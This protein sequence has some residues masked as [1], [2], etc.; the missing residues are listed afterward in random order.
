MGLELLTGG[1]SLPWGGYYGTCISAHDLEETLS[2]A[3]KPDTFVS[4]SVQQHTE[5][6]PVAENLRRVR[7]LSI[8]QR[9]REPEPGPQKHK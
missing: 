2:G 9:E 5:L 4:K 3:D 1:R 7:T 6:R 8:P